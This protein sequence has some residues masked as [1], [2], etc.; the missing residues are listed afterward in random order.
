MK[1]LF[2]L[3]LMFSVLAG[4]SQSTMR[5]LKCTM[6]GHDDSVEDSSFIELP[7]IYT[8]DIKTGQEYR[9]ED[10]KQDYIPKPVV[11]ESTGWHWETRTSISNNVF[12]GSYYSFPLEDPGD[13]FKDIIQIDLN[14]LKYSAEQELPAKIKSWGTC[15]WVEVGE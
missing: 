8:F 1:R 2:A 3:S 5:S 4:C 11:E 7:V 14:T 15:A 12:R 9:Y 6:E 13:A 10:G